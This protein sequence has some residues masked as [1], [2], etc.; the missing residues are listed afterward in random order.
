MR[1]RHEVAVVQ[2]PACGAQFDAP[3]WLILDGEE[4]PGLLQQL[5]DGRLRETQCPYCDAI[6]SL[7]APLLYH[8]A[9]YSQLILALPLSVASAS[10]AEALAQH[11]VGLLHQQLLLEQL[12]EAEYLG[13]V[14]LAAD[15]DDLQAMLDYAAKQRALLAFMA[16]SA[17]SWPQPATIELLEG[18]VQSHDPDQQQAFW[19]SL[20][21]AQQSDL[22]LM[23]DRL[24]T[25]VPMDSGLGDFLRR[26]IA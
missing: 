20:T 11:L 3:L 4:Q 5:L 24:A 7:I 26:F 1:S 8:D 16:N 18:L 9:R 22:T 15:L 17:W 21:V 12:A 10:E 14:Q 6:G 23:L 25:V 19:Q 2:C 13:H